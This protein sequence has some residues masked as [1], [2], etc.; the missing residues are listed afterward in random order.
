MLAC[1]LPPLQWTLFD[2]LGEPAAGTRPHGQSNWPQVSCNFGAFDLAGFAKP[3]A[4]FYRAWWLANV[5]PRSPGRPPIADA[6]RLVKIVHAWR[7]PAPPIVAVYSN[8]P[9]I[10]LFVN[11]ASLGRQRM[12][13]ANWTQWSP[14]FVPGNLT[15]VG[16][17]ASGAVAATDTQLTPGAAAKIQLSL[18]APAPATGTGTALLLD[19]ADAALVR[20]SVLDARGVL[21]TAAAAH[22]I[23]ITFAVLSGPGRVIGV[24]N[25]NPVSHEANKASS[26]VVHHG[27]A[28]AVV[29]VSVNAA[30]PD[31]AMQAAIDV[32]GNVSTRLYPPGSVYDGPDFITVQASA[33]GFAPATIRIPVSVDAQMHGV[34]A[35]AARSVR[36][37]LSID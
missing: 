9:T 13:W 8:L 37:P 35:V 36:T 24:G 15:A 21:V 29:Q 16:Y 14:A 3:A 31:R 11:G 30:T 25:G 10:E 20:A 33:A 12:A 2:Y 6:E 17:D 26:R 28:R 27:L 18:D 34:L 5:D 22:S 32:E 7:L 1:L 19:G 23:N 4:S